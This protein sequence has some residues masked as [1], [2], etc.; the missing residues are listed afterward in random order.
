MQPLGQSATT[1]TSVS[2][3]R[4]AEELAA[5]AAESIREV[6][7]EAEAKAAEIVRKAETEASRIRERA[8]ADAR[9]RIE[10]AQRALDEL[11][12][13]LGSV[14]ET[15][16]IDSPP[17]EPAPIAE[18]EPPMAPK[19]PT[20]PA[21]EAASPPEPETPAEQ[22]AGGGNGDDTAA[23]L[24]A[25]KLAVDGKGRADQSLRRRRPLGAARRRF[26]SRRPL[27]TRGAP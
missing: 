22:P 12:G 23:R 11:R 26:R 19:A 16:T 13:R 9:E 25:M 5:K 10:G 1:L 15:A 14:G 24:V 3:A 8:E 7:A 21:A 6:I 20:P 17:V 4:H 27:D 18:A 2:E